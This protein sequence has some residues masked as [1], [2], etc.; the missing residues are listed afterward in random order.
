MRSRPTAPENGTGRR[1]E[2]NCRGD[3]MGKSRIIIEEMADLVKKNANFILGNSNYI[4][5]LREM[6]ICLHRT[7]HKMVM[8]KKLY[9]VTNSAYRFTC[10]LCGFE[11]TVEDGNLT[12]AEYRAVVTAGIEP[13]QGKNGA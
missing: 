10:V 13:K 3:R 6:A 7:G 5:T 8:S 1:T 4:A 9:T 2:L 12:D 11:Y